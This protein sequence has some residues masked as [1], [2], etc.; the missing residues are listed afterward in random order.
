MKND[1][2]LTGPYC[3]SVYDTSNGGGGVGGYGIDTITITGGADTITIDPLIYSGGSSMSS[4]STFSWNQN[5]T[6]A[7][8]HNNVNI[9]SSGID[10]QPGTDIKIG[11]RSL[12]DAIDK[13]E[14]RL[15]I[16]H[17]NP[18][19]EDRW[20]QLKELRRMYNELEKDLLEKEKMWKI[21]KEK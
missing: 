2:I 14:E 9:S 13:I 18:E 17:P 4:A 21:L 5:Y 20:D 16:L 19:L 6:T 11:G 15:G 10:M 3:S 7:A 1:T 12:M 8:N